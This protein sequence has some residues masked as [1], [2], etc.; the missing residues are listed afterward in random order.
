MMMDLDDIGD[1]ID[2]ELE[3]F[4]LSERNQSILGSQN[5]NNESFGKKQVYEEMKTNNINIDHLVHMIKYSGT[6][7]CED[8][9]TQYTK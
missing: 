8:V 6:E 9:A 4:A 5:I 3:D 1:G 2:Y 7:G